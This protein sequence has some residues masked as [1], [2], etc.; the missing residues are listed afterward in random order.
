MFYKVV[1]GLVVTPMPSYIPSCH[2][3][4]NYSSYT[5]RS[6]S[7]YSKLLLIFIFP[8]AI[9][10]WNKRVRVDSLLGESYMYFWDLTDHE[11]L[12]IILDYT[13]LDDQQS[14]KLQIEQLGSLE[15]HTRRL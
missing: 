6:D 11:K 5:L 1:Y 12:R 10:R 7:Y 8:L 9:V 15:F 4:Q 2:N 3:D 14:G 13:V